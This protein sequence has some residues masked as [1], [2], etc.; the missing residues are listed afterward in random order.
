[1]HNGGNRHWRV[2]DPKAT[3]AGAKTFLPNS[4]LKLEVGD[5]EHAVRAEALLDRWGG[6]IRTT[7]KRIR[8][9]Q[10][11]WL[12]VP[13]L[14][15]MPIGERAE[16]YYTQDNPIIP[17]PL[18]HLQQGVN[19]LEGTCGA[20][21]DYGWG[22]WGLYSLI[23]R[24]Y[25]D[26]AQKAHPKGRMDAPTSGTALGENPTVRIT[27]I[28]R[29]GVARVDVIASYDGYDEN[30]DGVFRDW[31]RAYFQPL[32][33]APAEIREHVGTLWRHP[34]ELTWDTRWVPD[35]PPHSV[36][37][38][39][40][41]QDAHGIWFV[42]DVVDRLSLARRDNSVRLYR[43]VDVPR[44]FGVRTGAAKSCRIPIPSDD[45]LS[46]AIEAV[47]ALRTWHGWDGHHESLQL[48]GHALAISGKN[49]H[50]DYDLLTV[51]VGV[52]KRGDNI[53]AIH[54]RT[55]HHML[56][57]LWPGPALIVR[58]AIDETAIR[59]HATGHPIETGALRRGQRK[60]MPLHP[61]ASAFLEDLAAQN[62]PGWNEM[63]PN[64]GRAVFAGLTGLFGQGPAVHRV[65]N[66]TLGSGLR[67]R[68]YTAAATDKPLP[69]L[70]YFHGGGW[71]LGDLDTHDAL[72]R[73]LADEA[74][75]VVVAVDYRRAPEHKFPAALD[76]CFAATEFVVENAEAFG[77]DRDRVIVAGDS[78]G[79]NLAAAVA[80][81]AREQGGP[82]LTAQVLIYPV[83]DHRFDTPSYTQ[84]AEGYGLTRSAMVWFWEQYLGT[85]GDGAIEFASPLRAGDLRGLPPAH[86][87]TAG[88]D[89][90]R[91]E[92][93]RFAARLREAGVTTTTRRYDGMIHGFV[94]FCGLFD[95]GRQAVS[96]VAKVLRQRFER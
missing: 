58:S 12:T 4:V 38:V 91:D 24:V 82:A 61:Q 80:L 5:L 42:T 54:S 39:A 32:R 74:S 66:R 28:S 68:V 96:D 57:V 67:V 85:A 51:P 34:Y 41:I 93:E 60:V 1:M 23:L 31:H 69:A 30:G 59:R 3:A 70:M 11:S 46:G 94:H 62:A 13:E 17:V 20:L 22:Q 21:D 87:I 44:R 95:T 8:F 19:T 15:V 78:S 89:V 26:P 29:E 6:H 55:E 71:V 76:D 18:D 56:E 53:L 33:G 37:L 81:R 25:Y 79:G 65:E 40:R 47:L 49:H 27:P 50:Y 75:C 52:L 83:L 77:V 16:Y 63:T 86:V 7:G 64:E 84:F 14:A 36:K 45:D 35:Q 73:R 2:T 9:N 43:A 48:N 88:Y 92:G 72:C 10:R 90:L